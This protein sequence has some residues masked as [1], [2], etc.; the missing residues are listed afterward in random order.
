M[1]PPGLIA[2]IFKTPEKMRLGLLAQILSTRGCHFLPPGAR[3]KV[4]TRGE[5]GEKTAASGQRPHRHRT[6]TVQSY[7]PGG[8]NVHL[9]L[10]LIHSSLDIPDSAS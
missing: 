5:S 3:H 4:A 1:R 10:N 6:R 2:G 8:T 9:H 7:S